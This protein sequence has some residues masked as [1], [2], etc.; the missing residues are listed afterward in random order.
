MNNL[1][2]LVA[3]IKKLKETLIQVKKHLNISFEF[4]WC[5]LIKWITSLKLDKFDQLSATLTS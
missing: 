2:L 5:N 3:E 4:E 1:S